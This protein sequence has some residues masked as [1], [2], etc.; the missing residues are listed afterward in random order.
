MKKLLPICAAFLLCAMFSPAQ[1]VTKLNFSLQQKL[2]GAR[3]SDHEV[4]VFIQGDIAE[5]RS[6]TESLGGVFKYSAGDIAAVRV[7]LSK[8]PQLAASGKVQRIENN[9]LN[10]QPMNNQMLAN[11]HVLEVQQGFNLPQS[12]DGEGVV[13]G[14][15]D[16]GIDYT[17]P[18]FRDEFGRTRIKFLWDQAII[19]YD[20][21]TQAQPYGYGKEYIG[22]QIDTST[23]H[24]DSPFSHGSHVAGIACG[25]GLALNNY[26]GAAPHSD[27]IIVK[28]NLNRP[29]NEFLSS[30]VDAIK[31]IFDRADELGEPAVINVSLGTY[32][33]SHDGKDIQAQAIDNLISAKP[34][35]VVVCSAGNA[36]SA[37]LHLG[38]AAG[39]DTNFTWLQL[40]SQNM[41]IQ[42]WGDSAD[43]EN[44]QF[45]IGVDRVNHGYTLLSQ[46]PFNSVMHNLGVLYTDT[47]RAGT[48]RLGIIQCLS[49]YW[50]GN[51]SV[52]F[53]IQPDSVSN[54]TA[55]DTSRYFWRFMTTGQGRLDGWSYDMVFDNLPDSVSF[56][57]ILKY[58]KPDTDQ[59]IVSSFTCSDKVITV[60]SYINRNFYTNANYAI[61]RDTN[62]VVGALSGFSS[63]GP[64]RDGRIKPDITAT[65]EWLI[66]CG[67]QAELNLLAAIEPEKVAAGK[68]HKRSSGTSMSSPV[69]AGIAAL[70][71]QKNPTAQWD[72][73]KNAILNCADKD[74]FTGNNLPD[75]RWGYGKIN[76]YGV[77][78][79]CTVGIDELGD[80][81]S[82]NFVSYPNPFK[83]ST[84]IQYDLTVV[85]HYKQAEI[86]IT[87]LAG[88][89]LK[90]IPLTEKA[91]ILELNCRNW[92]PGMYTC[93]LHLDGK[94]IKTNKLIIL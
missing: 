84:A 33:G 67:T 19:N 53:L 2:S 58:K 93:S 42:A 51:Y 21:S 80:F 15:I 85:E 75:N 91:N 66:S 69:V 76:A 10:L 64:T 37:P 74:A 36:G 28:M 59:T 48:N 3:Q 31:Y 54:I 81:S 7:P 25:S 89:V 88:A 61:T 68:K 73:V 29:D 79:G 5:I 27:I 32:F 17:H 13:V 50:N 9:D 60:G 24:F 87:D 70:Y 26:K 44:I 56:P 46:L 45:S 49:Q 86:I 94:P 23:Q 16:E 65:G 20:T 6:L 18:D 43:F 34:G 82:I 77:V 55:T 47:L 38:Y 63:H 30:L 52:E 92:A 4:A 12:Y 57:Q 90:K 72:E 11:N 83:G 71:L 22:N 62:L 41:Y 40:S 8:I 35:R 78:K 1:Q 39:S 14:I